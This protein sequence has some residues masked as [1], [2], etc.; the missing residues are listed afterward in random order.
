MQVDEMSR[1]AAIEAVRDEVLALLAKMD[2]AAI[3]IKQVM[4]DEMD[5]LAVVPIWVADFLIDQAY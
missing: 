1:L 2:A 5:R 4:R 3:G